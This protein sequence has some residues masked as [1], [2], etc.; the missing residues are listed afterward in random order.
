MSLFKARKEKVCL[1]CSA[2]LQGPYCHKCGQENVETKET[3]WHLVTHFFKDITHFDGKFFRTL[4]YLVTRPGF[5]SK[6]YIAGRRASYVNPVRMYIFT[7]ALFFLIFFSFTHTESTSVQIDFREVPG[8]TYESVMVMD[9]SNFSNFAAKLN[10]KAKKRDSI[11]TKADLKNYVDS[12]YVYKRFDIFSDGYR[13]REHYD[14]LRKAG[15]VHD[16]WFK[17]QLIYKEFEV[18]DKYHSN[19]SEALSALG[20]IFLHSMPQMFFILLPLFALFLKLIYLRH[21]ELYYVDH[22]IFTLH[23]YIFSFIMMTLLVLIN[24]ADNKLSWSFLGWVNAVLVLSIFFYLY[25]AMRRFYKQRR[26]KTILKF[27]LICI[28]IVI[29]MAVISLGFFFLS[30]FKL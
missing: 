2:R 14:S 21:K 5:I 6:E 11:V 15:L 8:T 18:N 22:A 25:K 16:K 19:T 4:K 23:T 9:S 24:Q 13:S 26:G 20:N 7:S 29:S 28:F 12:H 17:R 1:N 27:F 10:R 3:A 30:L